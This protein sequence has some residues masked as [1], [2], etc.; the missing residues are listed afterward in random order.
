MSFVNIAVRVANCTLDVI[1]VNRQDFDQVKSLRSDVFQKYLDGIKDQS[2]VGNTGFSEVS[3]VVEIL[4]VVLD[5]ANAVK[6]A[7]VC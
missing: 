2:R 6:Q 5:D 1:I 7:K 4:N 3:R